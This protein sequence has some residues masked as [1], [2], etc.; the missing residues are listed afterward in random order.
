MASAAVTETPLGRASARAPNSDSLLSSYSANAA[1]C[2]VVDADLVFGEDFSASAGG[3]SAATPRQ[4][5]GN[6]TDYVPKDSSARVSSQVVGGKI[7]ASA[8]SEVRLS[9]MNAACVPGKNVANPEVS[10]MTRYKVSALTLTLFVLLYVP[11]NIS[12]GLTKADV[13]PSLDVRQ[14]VVSDKTGRAAVTVTT[15]DGEPELTMLASDGRGLR[16]GFGL[17]LPSI[18]FFDDKNRS[19][20]TISQNPEGDVNLYSESG[21]GAIRWKL[22][23]AGLTLQSDDEKSIVVIRHTSDGILLQNFPRP[24]QKV[25]P[26]R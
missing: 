5:S 7:L 16:I 11:L 10:I 18:Q 25:S 22:S 24:P 9:E 15:K 2:A 23:E 20:L 3:H 17:N 21:N 19:R 1:G 12:R 26:P 13:P 6:P 14:L 4:K 8:S